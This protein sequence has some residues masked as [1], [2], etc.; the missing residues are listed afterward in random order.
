[1][2]TVTILALLACIAVPIFADFDHLRARRDVVE[3]SGEGSGESSGEKPIVEASGEGSG[4]SSG[5][6]PVV[7]ASGEGSGEGSGASDGVLESS[8]E[9]SG[10][11]NTNAVVASDSPKDVKALTANEFAVSV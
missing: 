11:N 9:G 10:E 3:A 2:Q 6:K 5:D 8:G 1:M 7:E 4:E